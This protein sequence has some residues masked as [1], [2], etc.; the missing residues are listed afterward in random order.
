M[1]N[2]FSGKSKK[3]VPKTLDEC[4][5]PDRVSTNLWVWA[6]R[7]EKIG[8]IVFVFLIV[9]GIINTISTGITTYREVDAI[10]I[11]DEAAVATVLAVF[12]SLFST[13]LYAFI[14]FCAYHAIALLIGALASIVQNTNV[15]ANLA[16]YSI[17]GKSGDKF[18]E[19]P[20]DC[21]AAESY[22]DH[23]ADVDYGSIYDCEKI[24]RL[25]V[26]KTDGCVVCG[27]GVQ[28]LEKCALTTEIGTRK[29]FLCKTCIAKY[30]KLPIEEETQTDETDSNNS[31]YWR[32][33]NC[34]QLINSNPCQY[35]GK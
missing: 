28:N 16:L 30:S 29:L 15:S 6:E 8:V 3:Q 21:Q 35:C 7:I 34:G 4:V 20:D 13:A 19:E 33:N 2:M 12:T 32:C 5:Q 14:E 1:A 24:V 22:V 17:K 25:G 9:F 23:K 10:G 27:G 26:F 18:T 31:H 11:G